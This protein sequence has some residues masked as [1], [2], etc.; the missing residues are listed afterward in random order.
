MTSPIGTSIRRQEDHRFLT[1]RGRYL[2]DIRIPGM[3]HAAFVRSPHAHARVRRVVAETARLPGVVAVLTTAD[4]PRCG[5]SAPS[6][7][8]APAGARPWQ[9]PA[10]AGPGVR[11]VGEIVAVVVADDPYR[12]ADGARRCG[13][14]TKLCPWLP[15]SLPR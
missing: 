3:L 4:L 5:E 2:D 12:A 9:H 1:G 11:H 7:A 14:S 8:A 6:H 15:A 10:L 13:W